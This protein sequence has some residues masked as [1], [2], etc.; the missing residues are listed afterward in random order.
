MELTDGKFSIYR[1]IAES[2]AFTYYTQSPLLVAPVT[3]ESR[4]VSRVFD[5]PPQ[6]GLQLRLVTILNHR[7]V[8][9]DLIIINTKQ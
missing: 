3:L 4:Q 6:M 1:I 9:K 8:V 7:Q 2:Y 5:Y